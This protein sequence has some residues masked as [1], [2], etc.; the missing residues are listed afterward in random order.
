[1]SKPEDE[2]IPPDPIPDEAAVDP[3]IIAD[4]Y[5]KDVSEVDIITQLKQLQADYAALLPVDPFVEERK[6]I[7]LKIQYLRERVLRFSDPI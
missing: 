6:L 7:Q 5:A 2:I 4:T 3:T 1:M